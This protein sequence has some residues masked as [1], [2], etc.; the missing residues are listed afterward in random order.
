MKI[1]K[2]DT[3]NQQAE[4]PSIGVV[5]WF[6]PGE[7]DHVESV[8]ADLRKLG[9]KEIRTGISWADWYRPGARDWYH[10]LLPRLTKEVS[11]LP[12]LLYTPPSLGVEPKT[13]SP[14][15]DLKS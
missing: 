5:E 15:V 6:R 14:P 2:E 1:S 12:C 8:L 7:Y 13:S 10:W 3:I 4:T 9:V 11:V